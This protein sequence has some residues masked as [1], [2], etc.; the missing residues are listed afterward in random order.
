MRFTLSG[1]FNLIVFLLPTV[2][3]SADPLTALTLAGRYDGPNVAACSGTAICQASNTIT[4][5]APYL[6][7]TSMQATI[8]ASAGFTFNG[9]GYGL[10]GKPIPTGSS[11]L[12]ASLNTTQTASFGL[13]S[14]QQNPD[15]NLSALFYIPAES[16]GYQIHAFF[17]EGGDA[18]AIPTDSLTITSEDVFYQLT[19]PRCTGGFEGYSCVGTPS[20]DFTLLHDPGTSGSIEFYANSSAWYT[21]TDSVNF[22]VFLTPLTAPAATPEPGALS[23]LAFPLLAWLVAN[24]VRVRRQPASAERA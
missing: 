17:Y 10:D 3:A 16:S 12:T 13:T 4:I 18:N 9:A 8:D 14:Q 6:G 1:L 5:N 7:P 19:T 22:Q 24:A 2:P 21:G 15:V 20:A 23:L 11:V